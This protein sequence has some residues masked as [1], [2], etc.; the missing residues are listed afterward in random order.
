MEHQQ[1]ESMCD[2]GIFKNGGT[3]Y[4]IEESSHDVHMDQPL[5]FM[6]AFIKEVFGYDEQIIYLYRKEEEELEKIK[7]MD[8][9]SLDSSQSTKTSINLQ[10]NP[11]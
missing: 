11:V 1:V 10:Q 4:K 3:F 5:N 2:K 7:K 9:K 6:L 8:E